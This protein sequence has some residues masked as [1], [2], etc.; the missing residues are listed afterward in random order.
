MNRDVVLLPNFNRPEM[1]QIQMEL[2][3][4]NPGWNDNFHYIFSLDYGFKRDL[5]PLIRLWRSK[6]ASSELFEVSPM[7]GSYPRW[8]K[9]SRAIY[10]AYRRS[11]SHN[12]QYIFMLED[13]IAPS[14]IF[15]EWHYQVQQKF[16]PFCSIGTRNHSLMP[17][18]PQGNHNKEVFFHPSFQSLG[19]CWPGQNLSR[20]LDTYFPETYWRN[21]LGFTQ[22]TFP[23][24]KI[25][26]AYLEQDSVFNRAIEKEN[27]RVVY[28]TLPV[29]YHMGVYGKSTRTSRVTGTL[30]EKVRKLKSF[31]FD[32]VAV[33][34]RYRDAGRD[35]YFFEDSRPIPLKQVLV[36]CKLK[37]EDNNN[38]Q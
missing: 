5:L 23:G 17:P 25:P 2:I 11:L 31:I 9:Q 7:Q 30:D 24:T 16:K 35:E 3:T 32:P 36:G 29:A 27:L 18:I 21:P 1:L 4:E 8:L 20:I 33:E 12:P 34:K 6:M 28:P 38:G 15:F 14:N 37:P 10:K 13:D 26:L 22:K 19:V